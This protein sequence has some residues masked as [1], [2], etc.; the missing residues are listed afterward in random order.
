MEEIYS[1][2]ATDPRRRSQTPA[3][4]CTAKARVKTMIKAPTRGAPAWRARVHAGIF[5][6]IAVIKCAWNR[7]HNACVRAAERVKK[8]VF[9]AD[10]R[11]LA[12]IP[13]NIVDGNGIILR[14]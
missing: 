7:G 6:A 11:S 13:L 4:K 5:A 14:Y 2:R 9:S 1:E 8:R 10:F 3:N 12:R